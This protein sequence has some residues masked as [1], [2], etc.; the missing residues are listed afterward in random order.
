M[1]GAM[2]T[3]INTGKQIPICK[4]HFWIYMKTL[5]SEDRRECYMFYCPHCLQ[6]TAHIPDYSE[7]EFVKMAFKDYDKSNIGRR[8]KANKKKE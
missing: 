4:K 8:S 6:K 5:K 2:T 3:D 1:C 7:E